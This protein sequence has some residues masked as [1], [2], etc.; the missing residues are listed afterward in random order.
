M[1]QV[2]AS[3]TINPDESDAL[4]RYHEATTPL[5]EKAGARIVQQL[6][7]EDPVVGEMPGK[8]LMMIEY[9]SQEALEGVFNSAEYKSIIPYREKAFLEYNICIV[10]KDGPQTPKRLNVPRQNQWPRF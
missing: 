5:I 8:I 4:A 2:I 1:I 10:K 7:L 3:L 9:P 6:E